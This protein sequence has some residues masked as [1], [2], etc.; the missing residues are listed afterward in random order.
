MTKQPNPLNLKEQLYGSYTKTC[1]I[2]TPKGGKFVWKLERFPETEEQTENM[3][4]SIEY[5]GI[6]KGLINF[7]YPLTMVKGITNRHI[8]HIL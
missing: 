6:T 2:S 8:F 1:Q 5:S 7:I 3:K 4:F